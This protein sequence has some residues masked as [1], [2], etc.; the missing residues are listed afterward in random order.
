MKRPTAPGYG[1]YDSF[2]S[3]SKVQKDEFV[4]AYNAKF[5]AEQAKAIREPDVEFKAPANYD[6]RYD[7]MVVF[8]NAIKGEGKIVEDATFGLR[9]AAPSLACNIS[10]EKQKIVT[11]DP[12]TMKLGKMI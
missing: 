3:F 12:V 11:W 8:F 6:D 5:T 4:K 9:A 1:G 7:H 2:E 10:A